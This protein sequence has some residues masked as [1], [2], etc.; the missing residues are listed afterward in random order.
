[1]AA[2]AFA[3]ERR[4][5]VYGPEEAR[6]RG[7]TDP[8]AP[9]EPPFTRGITPR[10]YLDQPWIMGQYAGFGSAQETNARYRHL[11]AQGQT[12]FSVALDLPTQMGLDSDHPLA[13]GEVGK[14]G[15]AID[16]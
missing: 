14:V 6:A 11:L 2:D 15:V 10:M 13:R 16:S 4:V 7:A 9:G 3:A 1:M 5:E 12:G 8:G